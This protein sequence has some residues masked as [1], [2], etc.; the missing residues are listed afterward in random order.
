MK[1]KISNIALTLALL[2]IPAHLFSS[3]VSN[4]AP[5]EFNETQ[6]AHFKILKDKDDKDLSD[7]NKKLKKTLLNLQEFIDESEQFIKDLNKE[8]N[9]EQ[10]TRSLPATQGIQFDKNIFVSAN[11]YYLGTRASGNAT[12]A[13]SF[14]EL[15]TDTT[16]TPN[17][18]KARIKPLSPQK[19][20]VNSDEDK[21]NPIYNK[22]ISLISSMNFNPVVVPT[23]SDLGTKQ[24][25][26]VLNDS[27]NGESLYT[28]T[29]IFKDANELDSNE[30]AAISSSSSYVL[31]ALAPNGGTFGDDN[32]GIAV[33]RVSEV[34][35]KLQLKIY[36]ATSGEDGNKAVDVKNA[37]SNIPTNV[38][39][40]NN[41]TIHY[42]NTLNRFFVGLRGKV[43]ATG[44][45]FLS[46]LLVGRL[47]TNKLIL[48]SFIPSSAVDPNTATDKI[49]A[50]YR[51]PAIDEVVAIHKIKT[52]H[53]STGKSYVIV[54]GNIYADAG[55]IINTEVFAM[56]LVH[57]QY[58]DS[59]ITNEILGKAAKKTSVS[60]EEIVSAVTEITTKAEV[61]AIIGKGVT[62]ADIE[63]MFVVGD[64]V[65]VC[66]AHADK[67]KQGI[68]QSSALFDNNGLIQ[69]WTPWQRVMGNA[70]VAFGGA[71][72]QTIGN[73]W[74][75]TTGTNPR[76][77]VKITQ[78]G[79]GDDT[80][81]G[82]ER[83]RLATTFPQDKAGIHQ[84][85]NFDEKTTGFETD[86]FS[87]MVATGYDTISLVQT[88]KVDTGLFVPTIETDFATNNFEKKFEKDSVLKTVGPICCAEVSRSSTAA[89]GWL[90]VGGYNGLAVLRTVA[91]TGWT[92]LANVTTDLTSFSFKKI[93]TFKNVHKVV[94][95]GTNLY[96]MTP[97]KLYR[98]DMAAAK[99]DDAE[100]A[101]LGATEIATT[102]QVCGNTNHSFLDFT[103]SSKLCLL[104]TTNG[105]FRISNGEDI[106]T[107]GSPSWIEIQNTINNTTY[108]LG[109]VININTLSY[110][111]GS[112]ASGGN[113]YVLQGN[114]SVDLATVFRFNVADTSATAV[115][116]TTVQ[117]IAEPKMKSTDTNHD[118]FYPIGKMR[119]SFF[120]DGALG[121]HTMPNHFG[122]KDYLRKI[123]MSPRPGS[124]RHNDLIID[125]KTD[126]TAYNIG[127]PIKN[128][129]SGSWVIPGDWGI[130]VNE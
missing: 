44:G 9:E 19:A 94:C 40:N 38:T 70:E 89:E 50:M 18:I 128:T 48:E 22:E 84:L 58:S 49:A 106:A 105:L 77:T 82:K 75:L 65:F 103:I 2:C 67:N 46:G 66:L 93:G 28:N 62:A 90:F 123:Y 51:N 21:T 127:T 73:Y 1:I 36:N 110:E 109:P 24:S 15:Y 31:A 71:M 64:S 12:Y 98:I 3:K 17:A 88:G 124:I 7:E 30:I 118:Y 87:M 120:T 8:Q 95:D 111:K 114:M 29:A 97:T 37:A 55:S 92:T 27:I 96:V 10:I 43:N 86:E 45:T 13:L 69:S 39:L 117:Q 42:D 80:L 59:T 68:F 23:I 5:A 100:T 126:S 108:S 112:F 33:S 130:R 47:D 83:E 78:W 85:F 14:A 25:I 129:A 81:L 121:L 101:P 6:A 74:Y 122:R 54:N 116:D 4:I 113:V 32:S 104:A 115:S 61:P 52:M 91:G 63:D 119:A 60:Q 79:K 57:K 16:V 53:T 11:H 76:D 41:I 35:K 107:T 20:T 99:F 56:P 26:C 34:D 102:T 125:L 72:D